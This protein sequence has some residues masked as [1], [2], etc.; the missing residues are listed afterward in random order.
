VPPERF[1]AVRLRYMSVSSSSDAAE[2][3]AVAEA[4]VALAGG[5]VD[6][7]TRDLIDRMVRGEITGDQ[8]AAVL[9]E[10]F[11]EAPRAPR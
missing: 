11:T 8:A 1:G 10:Q 5:Q 9:V 7:A 2:A 3:V 6:P 4:A